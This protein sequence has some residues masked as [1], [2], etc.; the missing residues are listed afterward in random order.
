MIVVR[1]WPTCISLAT[2]GL[3]K[4]M[5]TRSGSA[6][7]SSAAAPV[8][9]R[10]TS[11]SSRRRKLTNALPLTS[12][13]LEH[14]AGVDRL[15]QLGGDLRR[16][17]A[18]RL[19]ERERRVDL[20]VAALAAAAV[21]L[22]EPRGLEVLGRAEL[23]G[24][25]AQPRGQEGERGGHAPMRSRA[26]LTRASVASRPSASSDSKSGGPTVLPGHRDADRRLRLAELQPALLAE[27]GGQRPSAARPPSSR[28]LV[29]R[30]GVAQDVAAPL[31]LDDRL[32]PRRL[33]DLDVAR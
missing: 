33:V 26:P 1:R 10:S 22:D 15:G 30:R 2:F 7:G 27:R 6:A 17:A 5:R 23:R 4:S 18:Q 9:T 11:H 21:A 13:G 8:V 24:R 29:L 19:R 20:H 3:E 31:V 12:P 14:R 25:V 32:L 16:V 28:R